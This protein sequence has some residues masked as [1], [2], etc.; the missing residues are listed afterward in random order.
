MRKFNWLNHREK[1]GKFVWSAKFGQR[2]YL[3]R[4]SIIEITNKLTKQTVK[5]FHCLQM[6]V[7]IQ[8]MS[9]VT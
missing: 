6:Y 1:S 9:E 5:A 7:R 2:P 4:I 3:F 8:L